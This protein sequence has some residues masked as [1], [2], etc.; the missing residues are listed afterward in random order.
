MASFYCYTAA[1]S[2]FTAK[3]TAIKTNDTPIEIYFLTYFMVN[4]DDFEETTP[5]VIQY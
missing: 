5:S 1:Q 3:A 2:Q 4:G